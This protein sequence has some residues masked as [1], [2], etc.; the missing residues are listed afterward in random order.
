MSRAV[1]IHMSQENSEESS[2]S[3]IASSHSFHLHLLAIWHY[4]KVRFSNLG[5]LN[6][7]FDVDIEER[8]VDLQKS[9]TLRNC[10]HQGQG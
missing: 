2:V 9:G 1:C 7:H 3:L 10:T 4:W 6:N 8:R 5:Y